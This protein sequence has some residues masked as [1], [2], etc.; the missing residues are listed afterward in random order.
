M[1][2]NLFTSR[3]VRRARALETYRAIEA[4]VS[5]EMAILRQDL[6]AA[7]RVTA[8]FEARRLDARRRE[9]S[10]HEAL[11]RLS[12]EVD[13]ARAVCDEDLVESQDPRV[14]E[15]LEWIQG[16][17]TRTA[18]ARS[19][20]VLEYGRDPDTGAR[21]AVKVV[22]N[23]DAVAAVLAALAAART[24]AADLAYVPAADLDTMIAA[25]KGSIPALADLEAAS[26]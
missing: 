4:R 25:I 2:L 11:T 12:Q 15:L 26:A 20:R 9:V 3:A 16:E 21:V 8:G 17:W 6:A 18:R 1:T 5:Q 19:A 14:P 13:R 7:E 22:S 24:A 10:L 23:H